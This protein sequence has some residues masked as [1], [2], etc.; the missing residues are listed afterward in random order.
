MTPSE[1]RAK[2]QLVKAGD[3]VTRY[4]AGTIPMDLN[5]VEVTDTLIICGWEFDRAT[6]AE[7][8]DFLGWGPPPKMTGSYITVKEEVNA[9]AAT[10]S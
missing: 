3:V 4:L 2:L 9:D 8:D 10:A 5:V 1:N 7:V 6:G